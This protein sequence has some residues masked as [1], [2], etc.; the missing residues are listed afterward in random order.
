MIGLL[1]P[2]CLQAVMYQCVNSSGA[3]MYTDTPVQLSQCKSVS[4]DNI[5]SP[6]TGRPAGVLPSEI[7]LSFPILSPTGGEEKVRG[8]GIHV[9]Q[10][11]R[12]GHL[13]VVQTRLNQSREVRLI[14]DTGASHTI[15][16]R[17]IARD[18]GVLSTS[19]P[20]VVTL[21]TAGGPIQAEM[22]RLDTIQ[23]GEAEAH[24]VPVAIHDLPDAPPGIDGLLG[25]T[26]LH[27]FLVTLDMHKSELRLQRQN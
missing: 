18:L 23:V 16:S 22:I 8:A 15:L 1:M 10:V 7:G 11:Q 6:S 20:T 12:E 9:I 19:H 3:R 24:N 5:S 2:P 4:T 17:R 25:L 21:K 13:L 14:L 26:F 27:T